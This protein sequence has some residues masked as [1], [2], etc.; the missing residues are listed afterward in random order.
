MT[1]A[2]RVQAGTAWLD[3]ALPGWADK[4]DLDRLNLASSCNCILG[5]LNHDLVLAKHGRLWWGRMR[6]WLKQ[7][8][9]GLTPVEYLK[10]YGYG[11]LA[12][13]YNRSS[14]TNMMSGREAVSLGFTTNGKT[15]AP[16]NR[17]WHKIIKA[18]R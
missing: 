10:E 16:L 13:G 3:D 9:S 14:P 8:N 17:E 18:R 7:H 4:V 6:T 2:T 15:W 11:A 12:S 1:T 5:Q